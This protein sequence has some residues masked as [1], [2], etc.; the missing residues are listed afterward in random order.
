M[1]DSPL[2]RGVHHRAIVV[3]ALSLA[4]VVGVGVTALAAPPNVL[5]ILVDDLGYGDLSC[6]GARDMKTP[7]LDGLA[8]SGIS[9]TNFYANCPVCSPTRAALLTG[10][11]QDLVG[12]P[13]VIRTHAD[14][15]WGYL[16]PEAVL[17]P[18]VMKRA[19]YHTAMIG[20][21]HLGLE[22]PNL[23][24]DRG[25]EFFHGF[26]GD[27]M[28]DYYKHRRHGINYMRK[29][30]KT[31]DPPGHASD[32]FTGWTVDHLKAIAASQD[33]R[34]FFLYLAYNAPHTPIQPPEDWVQR[35]VKR[36]SKIDRR[37]ARLVAL[38]EHMDAGIG[39]V[40]ETLKTTGQAGNTLV[41]FSSDN[42]GQLSVGANN[43]PVR[44]GKQSVYEGGLRVPTFV[45]WPGRIKPGSRTDF[46]ALSM[47][48]FPL[49]CEAAGI[50]P[51]VGIEGRSFLP[52]LL[53]K[54]QERLRTLWFFSRREGGRRYGGKTIEA[55]R[56]GPWKLLQN[57]PF[58]PL[59][60]YNLETDPREQKD[61]ARTNPKVFRELSSALRKQLQRYGKV[62]W[63]KPVGRV[64]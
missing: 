26:L 24:N 46:M 5:L 39:R 35:V 12:V 41:I 44:D 47:D 37:R 62:P 50:R 28:D 52:T 4:S 18:S 13:G 32:L 30:E 15:N 38:I 11:Y 20:K 43:G 53:G 3:L 61:L 57:S 36:E 21:W 58:Q 23:P 60:L 51:P 34:P 16:R 42:G 9:F 31:I 40:L 14:N 25:F 27:M 19:G 1:C 63:Q 59:E 10:R 55:V 48:L 6:Y 29:N 54:S 22:S 2:V 33:K 64:E 45:S 49:V 56:R 17:L 7:H 8:A